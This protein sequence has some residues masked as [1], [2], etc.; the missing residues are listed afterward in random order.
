MAPANLRPRRTRLLLAQNPDDLLFAKPALPH[1]PSP[2]DGL[3]FQLRE[4]AGSRSISNPRFQSYSRAEREGIEAEIVNLFSYVFSSIDNPLTDPMRTALSYMVRLLLTIPGANI[5]TFRNLLEEN[6]KY[7]GSKFKEHIEKL[8]LGKP[9]SSARDFFKVQFFTDR[10][11]STKTS[12]LQRLSSI[13]SVGA[14]ERMFSTTNK[15]DFYEHLQTN[16]SIILVNTSERIL[17]ENG[18]PL[19]GRYIIARVM[20][21]AFERAAISEHERR[22]SLLIV[23]EAA[24]YFDDTFEKLLTRVRQ[25]KLGAFLA[26]QHL[27]Q[28][29][30]KLRSAISSSTSVKLAGGLG[31]SDSRSLAHDMETEPEFLKSQRKDENDPPQWTSLACHVRNFTDRALSIRVPFFALENMSQMSALD[32]EA[33]LRFNRY[34]VAPSPSSSGPRGSGLPR[35]D[36]TDN[37]FSGP[38]LNPRPKEMEKW[39]LDSAD[40][41]TKSPPQDDPDASPDWK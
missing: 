16:G 6:N 7:E 20:A 39:R 3:S 8:D 9:Q 2:F 40:E 10:V 24:P 1:R 22:P 27:E 26:F 14:F 18:S 23:D 31:F 38:R 21:S 12:I 32:H 13:L 36:P 33:L 30:P 11:A 35:I 15:I 28:A 25:H 5:T 17:K 41:P 37:E 19:F 34:L 29:S 4:L